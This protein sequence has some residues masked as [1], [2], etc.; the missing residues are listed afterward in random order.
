MKKLVIGASL[1][2]AGLLFSCSGGAGPEETAKL[3]LDAVN[4]ED[5]EK[6]KEYSTKETAGIIGIFVHSR[7]TNIQRRP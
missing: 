5:F 3:Y 7:R 1:A 4:A 2:V 6:A